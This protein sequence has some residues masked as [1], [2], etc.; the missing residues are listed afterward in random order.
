MYK[1]TIDEAISSLEAIIKV[2]QTQMSFEEIKDN[3]DV[4]VKYLQSNYEQ[5]YIE[6]L[7][8]NQEKNKWN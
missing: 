7:L 4:L 2:M 3:I 5:K 1:V 6:K 8:S